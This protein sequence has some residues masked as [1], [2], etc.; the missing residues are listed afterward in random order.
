MILQKNI[1]KQDQQYATTDLKQRTNEHLDSVV[2][3][4][5]MRIAHLKKE[6]DGFKSQYLHM[7]HFSI[8]YAI[9]VWIPLKARDHHW[10]TAIELQRALYKYLKFD[11]KMTNINKYLYD[12][13]LLQLFVL[14]K[15]GKSY[16]YKVKSLTNNN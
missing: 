12:L 5:F 14:K 10:F 13:C 1:S 3:H 8:V 6:D 11:M 2:M 7:G 9:W 15:S 16:R 4:T